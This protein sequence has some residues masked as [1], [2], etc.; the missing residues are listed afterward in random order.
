MAK[1]KFE[2]SMKHQ[3]FQDSKVKYQDSSKGEAQIRNPPAYAWFVSATQRNGPVTTFNS[4][5]ILR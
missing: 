4:F 3:D 2:R 5:I 1:L